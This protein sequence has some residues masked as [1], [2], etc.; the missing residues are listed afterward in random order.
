MFGVALAFTFSMLVGFGFASILVFLL[1]SYAFYTLFKNR[2]L[3][4]IKKRRQK[5][6]KDLLFAGQYMLVKLESG[7]P[8]FNT[9]IH[10]SRE[11]N[12]TGFFF[13]EIV[14]DINTGTPIEQAL[15]KARDYCPS[16]NMKRI[17][18]EIVTSLRTGADVTDTLKNSIKEISRALLL[19]V[20]AYGKK[21]NSLM[22]F[23]MIVGTVL[24]SIGVSL[25]IIFFSFAGIIMDTSLLIITAFLLAVM[26]LF[27]IAVVNNSR[28]T[29]N[30]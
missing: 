14:Q 2:P 4:V 11:Y 24:P 7:L 28:P 9:L 15:T 20:K 10:A 27:F 8:L 23:Y 1:S 21:L 13:R 3:L 17:L 16:P 30:V 12:E 25:V 18:S 6:D 19:E 29:V 5:I 26:Q 22:M